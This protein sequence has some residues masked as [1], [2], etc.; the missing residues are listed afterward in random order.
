MKRYEQTAFTSAD[1]YKLGHADQYPVGTEYV[2]V[3]FTPR[4]NQHRKDNGSRS[5]DDSIV[6]C[7]TQFFL[8]EL[9]GVF[10]DS[11]FDLPKDEAIKNIVKF[12]A[13]FCG[14]NGFNA[15]RL[16]ELHDLGFLPLEIKS[17]PEGTFVPM[18]VPALT[19][20]NTDARFYWLP[21]F[22]ETWLSTT[23]WL[24]STSATTARNYR[25]ILN[26]YVKL[27]GGDANFAD[28]QLHD[29]SARGM[30]NIA[31]GAISGLGHLLF[32]CGTDSL[33]AVKLIHDVYDGEATFVGGSVPATEHSVMC[34]GGEDSELATY[35]RLLDI[36]PSGVISIVSDTWDY[37]NVITK[38]AKILKD[39][40]LARTPDDNGLAK[41]VF[42]PDSGDPV[43][44]ICG[45]STSE[46][47]NVNGSYIVKKTGQEISEA[48]YLGSVR[49]L[50]RVFGS[51]TN[52]LGFKTLNPRVGLIYGDSITIERCEAILN[53][54][55]NMGYA[56]DNIVFG[57][58]SYTYQYV[59]RDTDGWAMKA[60]YVCID[61]QEKAI[62]KN[63]KTDNGVKKSAKGFVSV[64]IED[65]HLV[66]H[67][68][69]NKDDSIENDALKTVFVDGV[70]R[71]NETFAAM[72]SRAKQSLLI[73]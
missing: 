12:N 68:S 42:R 10:K 36:Y 64:L 56:S 2:Q 58:G 1:S 70:I 48:E 31:A 41:V 5:L 7:G 38:T 32:S 37:W 46:V 13:A 57:V 8:L 44:I 71:S 22:I 51:S 62:S 40:I 35:S 55:Y 39:K 17:L 60:T 25:N 47:T 30:E 34:A 11:F 72:R 19:C 24:P 29:F 26:R 33:A 65:G 66:L 3:N 73:N 28:W 67:E 9:V 49:C 63:P 59:T 14:P 23:M 4:S 53:I 50:E 6:W 45:Y 16:E 54:L 15:S 52:A 27:T 18:R 20:I 43:R 21:N 69:S 61:G